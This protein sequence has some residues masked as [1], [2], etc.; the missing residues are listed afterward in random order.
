LREGSHLAFRIV[1]PQNNSGDQLLPV[2]G[3]VKENKATESASK[4]TSQPESGGVAFYEWGSIR[5]ISLL[6]V[7]LKPRINRTKSIGHV[8]CSNQYEVQKCMNGFILF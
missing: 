7:S 5:N 3:T 2:Y 4:S 1:E 6:S 8:V